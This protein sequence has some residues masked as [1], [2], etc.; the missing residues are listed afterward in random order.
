M[1]LAELAGLVRRGGH[2]IW[3]VTCVGLH[4][5]LAGISRTLKTLNKTRSE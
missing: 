3:H 4:R 2:V 1:R 5:T